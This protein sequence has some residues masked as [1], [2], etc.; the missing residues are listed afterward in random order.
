MK[1]RLTGLAIFSA[2]LAGTVGMALTPVL[3]NSQSVDISYT[4]GINGSGY[5]SGKENGVWHSFRNNRTVTLDVSSKGGS[6]TIDCSLYRSDALFDS[7]YGDVTISSTGAHSFPT[8]TD[9][10]SGSY[11]LYLY[12]G[13]VN[14]T[15]SVKGTI[16]D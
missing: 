7:Y 3:A 15:M 14:T 10:E 11:Y 4:T 9:A 5:V 8:Q 16:H 13:S 2:T 6:G 12:G 1:N